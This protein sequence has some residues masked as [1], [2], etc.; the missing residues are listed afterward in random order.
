M[1]PALRYADLLAEA[2]SRVSELM[3]WDLL[4]LLEGPAPPLVVDVREPHEFAQLRI[5]GSLGVPRGV[6]EAA[7]EWDYDDTVPALAAARG[8]TVVLVCRSGNRSLLAADTLRRLGFADAA[9]LATGLRGWNDAE[10]PLVTGDGR[11]VDPDTAEP[12]LAA[13]VRPEQR[14]PRSAA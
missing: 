14:R 5:E 2:R 12:L 3:P 4:G 6:L 9:S 1:T 8:R 10:Q 7:C 11:P 13:R